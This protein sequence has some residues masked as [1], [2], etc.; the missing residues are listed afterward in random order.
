MTD[1]D[2]QADALIG[3]YRRLLDAKVDDQVAGVLTIDVNKAMCAG[4][5]EAAQSRDEKAERDAAS[6]AKAERRAAEL[7]QT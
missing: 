5:V 6:R 7:A 2:K 3:F 4:T 1:L